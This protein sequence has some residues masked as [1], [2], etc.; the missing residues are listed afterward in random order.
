MLQCYKSS[1]FRTLNNV[2]RNTYDE[3]G[4]GRKL[5][6]D[7]LLSNQLHHRVAIHVTELPEGLHLGWQTFQ[8]TGVCN[9]S[10]KELWLETEPPINLRSLNFLVEVYTKVYK[11]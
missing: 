2:H 5:S 9:E 6:A 11:F 4:Y 10:G 1:E 3:G 8:Q 7:N